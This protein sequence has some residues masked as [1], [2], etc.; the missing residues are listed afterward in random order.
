MNKK[1]ELEL[2]EQ[3]KK[4]PHSLKYL[5][6]Q[7]EAIC[8][9]AVKVNGY[10]LLHVKNQTKEICLAALE[11][12]SFALMYVKDQTEEICLE[13][14]RIDKEAIQCVED[15]NKTLKVCKR[16]NDVELAIKY[17]NLKLKEH[18]LVALNLLI[19]DKNKD[20]YRRILTKMIKKFNNKEFRSFYTKYDLWK[21]VDFS[22]VENLNEY[23]MVV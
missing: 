1:L 3:V 11:Q 13:A 16:L 22:K 8:L 4:D 17:L 2:I 21:Y 10:T 18:C 5:N 9:A 20:K 19:F 12:D 6:D 15:K 14:V 23:S 7:T